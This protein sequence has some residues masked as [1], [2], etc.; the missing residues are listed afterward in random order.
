[1]VVE[2]SELPPVAVDGEQENGDMA[3]ETAVRTMGALQDC[4]RD[5]QRRKPSR[6]RRPEVRNL[7]RSTRKDELL[8]RLRDERGL[9][10]KQIGEYFP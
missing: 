2:N 3:G 6:Q 8:I 5:A 4:E 7:A 10:W 9:T 1:M